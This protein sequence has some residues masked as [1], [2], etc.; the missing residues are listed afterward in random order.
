MIRWI[1]CH[2][3]GKHDYVYIGTYGG[4]LCRNCN[5]FYGENR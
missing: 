1:K 3:F 5:K 4:T 2:I